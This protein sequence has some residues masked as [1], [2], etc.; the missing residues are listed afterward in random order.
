MNSTYSTAPPPPNIPAG[1][2]LIRETGFNAAK[3]IFLFP[4]SW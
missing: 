1:W 2:F 4:G 3:S